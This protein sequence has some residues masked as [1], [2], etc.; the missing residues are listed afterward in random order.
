MAT[1]TASFSYDTIRHRRLARWLESLESGGKSRAIRDAL[2][3]WLSQDVSNKEILDAIRDL[4][5]SGGVVG[6]IMDS[7][8]EEDDIPA[9]VHEA[10][11]KLVE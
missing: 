2:S 8:G 6:Q 9:S 7:N 1:A 5:R 11:H 3:E 4:Q 10:L